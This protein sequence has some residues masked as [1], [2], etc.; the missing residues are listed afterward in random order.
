MNMM[1]LRMPPQLYE[2]VKAEALKEHLS[3]NEFAIRALSKAVDHRKQLRD[4][5]IERIAIEDAEI[6]RRLAE[7]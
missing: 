3:A 1:T 7:K 2:A 4:E 6:F 5:L